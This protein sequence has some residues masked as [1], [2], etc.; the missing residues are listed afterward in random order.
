MSIKAPKQSAI[1]SLE[2]A[3]TIVDH[4]LAHGRGLGLPSMTVSVL[5]GGGHLVAMKRED[6][7]SILRPQ[8]A[9]GK[10]YGAL[11][12]GVSSR[13]LAARATSHPAFVA[14]ITALAGGSLIPVPGGVLVRNED[15]RL[16]GAV[17]VS[18][19]D[20]DMDEACAVAGI[21]AAGLSADVG[22]AH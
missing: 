19:A 22:G 7:S 3:S 17:G 9:H 14:S 2:D 15:G 12:M 16:I 5:D 4:A 20:P 6:G 21:V 18:G 1:I 13:D 11:A 10:A 8:I